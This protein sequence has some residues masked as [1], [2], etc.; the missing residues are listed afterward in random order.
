MSR[1]HLTAAVERMEMARR[2]TKEFIG[3]LTPDEWF[4]HP[5]EFTTH[6]AWQIGH[7]AVSQYNLC[8]RRVRGRTDADETL[9]PEAFIEHFKLG[10][11][12][13]AGAENYPPLAEI[14]RVF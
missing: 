9:M 2:R 10:S 6:I 12:P 1:T 14:Q 8:L 11:R 13:A 4:W 3:D 7:L 5:A